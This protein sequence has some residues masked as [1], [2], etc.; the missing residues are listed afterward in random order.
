MEELLKLISSLYPQ[1]RVHPGI[2]LSYLTDKSCFYAA[3]HVFPNGL[4]SREIVARSVHPDLALCLEELKC[5]LMQSCA[6]VE[7]PSPTS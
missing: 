4:S 5:R 7:E 6:P 3:V 2:Q 1:H